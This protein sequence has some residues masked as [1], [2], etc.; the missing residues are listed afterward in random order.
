M[1][2]L[3]ETTE[4]IQEEYNPDLSLNF[5]CKF[6]D[7]MSLGT[8]NFLQVGPFISKAEE[9]SLL[10]SVSLFYRKVKQMCCRET[11]LSL[12]E[13]PPLSQSALLGRCP[14]SLF[15]TEYQAWEG[16]HNKSNQTN[17]SHEV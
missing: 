5:M 15:G 16:K 13:G 8:L 2:Q 11:A 12:R 14:T 3:S 17:S 1:V 6:S 9:K 7:F 4:T 10:Y